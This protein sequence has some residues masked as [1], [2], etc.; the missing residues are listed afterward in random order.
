M[1]KKWFGADDHCLFGDIKS[2]CRN[3]LSD[4]V[5]INPKKVKWLTSA[6]CHQHDKE[7][8]INLPD[9]ANTSSIGVLGS[10][11]Q[12]FSQNLGFKQLQLR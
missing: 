4:D 7:C 2:M 10:P 5:L 8:P 9:A 1:L 6:W 3:K 11:C 12:L